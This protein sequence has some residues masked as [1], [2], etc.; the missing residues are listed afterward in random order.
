MEVKRLL[1][2]QCPIVR[3]NALVGGKYK[4]RILWELRG[5]PQRYSEVQRALS[6]AMCGASITPRVL[7]RE[8]R[9]LA[10][11]GLIA[12]KQYPVIPPKV[13]Y[14]LTPKGRAM[15]VVMKSICR[16]GEAGSGVNAA[17]V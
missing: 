15:M 4:L 13:E 1:Q 17:Q 16:W 11:V 8:L 12:R 5:P 14:R 2:S 10:E 7:S 3:F 9:E 6:A